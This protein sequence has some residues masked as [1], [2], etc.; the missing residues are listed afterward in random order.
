MKIIH[1][2]DWHLGQSFYGMERT[3]EHLAFLSQLCDTVKVERPDAL[4][5]SGDIYDSVAPSLTAQRLYNK[6]MLELH[7]TLPEMKIVVTAGNHDSSSR[8]ELHSDL[9]DAFDV[10]I[11][12]NIERTDEGVN[13]EKHIIEIEGKGYIVAIPYIYQ[14][15]Y[16]ATTDGEQASRMRHFHQTL[17]DNV[18]LRNSNNLPVIMTGHLAVSGADIKGHESK[19]MRLV[20]EK[21]E[22]LGSGYDYLALGHIHHPQFVTHSTNARYSG[23]PIPMNFDEEYPHSITIVE[24][25]SYDTAPMVRA[26][27]IAPLVPVITIPEKGGDCNEV[28]Q[29]IESLPDSR[30]YTRVRLKVNDV[31]PM[32]ERKRIE[33]AFEGKKAIL[34]EIQPIREKQEAAESRN[35]VI[36]EMKMISPMEIAAD[37]YE[38]RFGTAMDSELKAMLEECM[39]ILEKEEEV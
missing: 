33:E 29:C 28:V 27:E 24:I 14:A 16:P 36:E 26:Q 22:E 18:A 10:K 17:L 31:I 37:Y 8:L 3:E 39:D 15:N 32:H 21:L 19:S 7:G 25:E 9:W 30:I 35:L 6:M 34:C 2:S 38:K 11:V 1:T 23:S 12:G 13:Y 4:I 20:Y 5:I